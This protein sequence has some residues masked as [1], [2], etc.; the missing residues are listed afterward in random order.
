MRRYLT[1]I[2][3]SLTFIA[4]GGAALWRQS[5]SVLQMLITPTG[6]EIRLIVAK[7][8]EERVR[9]LS[10]REYMNPDEGMLFVFP[11]DGVYPFWMR[12]MHFPLDIIWID[13]GL[14]V[15]HK[16]EEVATSTYPLLYE[17][18]GKARYVLEVHAG[19]A[20]SMGMQVGEKM[21]FAR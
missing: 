6:E 5:A 3:I 11:E 14:E 19:V 1:L 18:P 12:G 10:G 2:V 20:E 7:T 13:A 4:V 16:E 8:D 17:P 9:G 15:V 21:R